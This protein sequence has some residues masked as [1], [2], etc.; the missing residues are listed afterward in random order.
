[1]RFGVRAAA[2]KQSVPGSTRLRIVL[3]SRGRRLH[4]RQSGWCCAASPGTQILLKTRIYRQ[5][6]Q[7][8]P[9]HV[10]AFTTVPPH[11]HAQ[12]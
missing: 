10:R 9:R 5:V 7:I 11:P 12:T 8:H 2:S 6:P 1:M 4:S 3:A